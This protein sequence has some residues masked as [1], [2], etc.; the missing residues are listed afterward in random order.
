MSLQSS[1]S[2]TLRINHHSEITC[3]LDTLFFFFFWQLQQIPRSRE[4]LMG[5][6]ELGGGCLAWLFFEERGQGWPQPPSGFASARLGF[7]QSWA[8]GPVAWL[9]L[10]G[11]WLAGFLY[12]ANEGSGRRGGGGAAFVLHL[13]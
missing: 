4:R 11:A 7:S 13:S 6:V 1:D 12:D 5:W 8:A 10:R 3:F 2:I 9:R